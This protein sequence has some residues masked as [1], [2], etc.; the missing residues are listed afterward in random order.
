MTE[1]KLFFAMQQLQTW[2]QPAKI[3]FSAATDS[4]FLNYIAEF[5]NSKPT[6]GSCYKYLSVATIRGNHKSF[7]AIKKNITVSHSNILRIQGF[8]IFSLM[9]V[10]LRILAIIS[11][12]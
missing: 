9:E 5:G 10:W 12:M 8:L 4:N 7:A 3:T 6:F 11:Y 1:S 2:S